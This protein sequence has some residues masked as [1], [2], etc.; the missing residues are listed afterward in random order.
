MRGRMAA[1]MFGRHSRPM[2][3]GSLPGWAETQQSACG[4][5]GGSGVAP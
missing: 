5:C 4:I 1:S 2:R 3:E